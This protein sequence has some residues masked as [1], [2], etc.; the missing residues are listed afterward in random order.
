MVV[1]TEVKIYPTTPSPHT[2]MT[3]LSKALKFP[4]VTSANLLMAATATEVNSAKTALSS[5]ISSFTATIFLRGKDT[6]SHE[7][8]SILLDANFALGQ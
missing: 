5:S 3:L 1:S 6:Y 8:P 2:P 4:R 7:K